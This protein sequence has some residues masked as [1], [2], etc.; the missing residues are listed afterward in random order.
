MSK[1]SILFKSI[2]CV[3]AFLIFW[4]LMFLAAYIDDAT[5]HPFYMAIAFGIICGTVIAIVTGCAEMKRTFLARIIGGL[6]VIATDFILSISGIPHQIILYKYRNDAFI[7]ETGR[8]TV[9]ESIAF[10]W[11]NMFFWY[12]LLIAFAV[13]CIG[14]FI[15]NIMK[16]RKLKKQMILNGIS[17]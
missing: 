12:A 5:L 7:R 1:R 10:G 8:I 2:I 11:S 9:N 15:Y 3:S 16:T 13:V 17:Q 4:S 6:S 14:V